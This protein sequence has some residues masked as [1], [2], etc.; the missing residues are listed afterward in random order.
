MFYIYTEKTVDGVKQVI[1]DKLDTGGGDGLSAYARCALYGATAAHLDTEI[2]G[3]RWCFDYTIDMAEGVFG[4]VVEIHREDGIHVG[5]VTAVLSETL[6]PPEEGAEDY[7][8]VWPIACF[9]ILPQGIR[10]VDWIEWGDGVVENPED[11]V[12][13]DYWHERPTP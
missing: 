3:K 2:G 7:A 6:D 1:I 4:D 12:P 9:E 8:P 10:H 11:P 5:I 13:Y